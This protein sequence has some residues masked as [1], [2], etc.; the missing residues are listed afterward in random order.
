MPARKSDMTTAALPR[1]P[2]LC[3][4]KANVAFSAAPAAVAQ[5]RNI[6]FPLL[7]ARHIWPPHA[8]LLCGGAVVESRMHLHRC[9]CC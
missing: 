3:W 5:Y 6:M 7:A 4:T 1:R 9:A 2:S 8:A